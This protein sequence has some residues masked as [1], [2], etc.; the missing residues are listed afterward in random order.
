MSEKFTPKSPEVEAPKIDHE[1]LHERQEKEAIK[2]EKSKEAQDETVEKIRSSVETKAKSSQEYSQTKEKAKQHHPVLVNKQ[3]KDMAYSRA[4]VRT[5]K[6]LSAPS[7]AFSKV[8][9][10][11]V[12]DKPSEAIGKTVARPSGMVGGALLAF[13]GTSILLWVTKRYGYEYNYLA[14]MLLFGIGMVVGLGLEGLFKIL[15]KR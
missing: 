6:H 7:R 12:M 14:V 3:L 13:V 4:M 9:H 5:R 1:S 15:K 10:S 8:V 2:H 11:K